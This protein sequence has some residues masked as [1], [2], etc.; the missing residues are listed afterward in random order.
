MAKVVECLYSKEEALSSKQI[1]Q[2]KEEK[3][4]PEFRSQI[5][6]LLFI[7]VKQVAR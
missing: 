3:K 7:S 4:N 5:L 6:H 2:K 1:P